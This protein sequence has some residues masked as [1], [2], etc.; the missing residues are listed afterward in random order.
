MKR[1]ANPIAVLLLSSAP[2]Y[3]LAEGNDLTNKGTG[4]VTDLLEFFGSSNEV[5]LSGGMDWGVLPGPFANPEQGVGIGVAAVGLYAPQGLE[6]G[7]QLSTLTLSGYVSSE[8]TY[9]IGVDNT[10][11]LNQNQWKLGLMGRL[12]QTPSKYWGVG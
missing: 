4:W 9:G 10:T 5:D 1:L 12:S 6:T 8:G 7:N 11:F 3:A 2:F